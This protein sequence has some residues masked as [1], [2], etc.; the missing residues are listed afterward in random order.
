M[1]YKMP[2]KLSILKVL[3]FDSLYYSEFNSNEKNLSDAEYKDE[4]IDVSD[5]LSNKL[6]KI[7]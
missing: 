6:Q 7:V 4:N 5:E 1:S 2:Q 3:D